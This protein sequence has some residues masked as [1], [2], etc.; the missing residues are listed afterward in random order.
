MAFHNSATYQAD[1]E[2][3]TAHVAAQR[4]NTHG[5]SSFFALTGDPAREGY[6]VG[7]AGLPE[8]EHFNKNLS[9]EQFQAN[10]DR[11]RTSVAGQSPDV[12][13][14]AVAGGW[15]RRNVEGK[16]DAH[17]M[18]KSDVLPDRASAVALGRSRGED[19]IWHLDGEK[20]IS[21]R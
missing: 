14:R 3:I 21:T 2:P 4:Q 20:E 5:G 9:P 6:A 8:V 1:L 18:D 15:S 7:G 17:V 16:Q 19:A 10:R 11:V 13:M 12:Q